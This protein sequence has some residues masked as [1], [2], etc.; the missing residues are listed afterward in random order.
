MQINPDVFKAY[1]IRGLYPTEINEEVAR[2]VGRGLSAYLRVPCIGISR[3]MRISSPSIAAA[4]IEGIRSQGTD[5]VDYGMMGTDMLYFAVVRDGLGGGAQ[6]TAS[7]NPRQY[8]GV[9]M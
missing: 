5:V 8:N 4:L 6:V 1:D 2:L 7:H 9:K 3:D